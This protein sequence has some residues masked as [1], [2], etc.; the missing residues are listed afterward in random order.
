[1]K[2]F[3]TMEYRLYPDKEQVQSITDCLELEDGLFNRMADAAN[4]MKAAG[5]SEEAIAE[6]VSRVGAELRYGKTTV[7]AVKAQFRPQLSRLMSG[8]IERI[9]HRSR[10]RAERMADVWI[11]STTEDSAS[12]SGVGAVPVVWHRRIPEEAHIY[13]A[14][15]KESCYGARYYL[16]YYY[17]FEEKSVNPVPVQPDRI[18]GLDYAQDGLYVDSNGQSAGYPGFRLRERERLVRYRAN[19][20]RFKPGSRRWKT[21]R[22]RLAKL[23]THINNQRR[24]WQRKKVNELVRD[25]DMVCREQLDMKEMGEQTPMLLPK[26]RDNDWNSF[27][28]KLEAKM[29]QA[30][31]PVVTVDRFYPSSQICSVCGRRFGKIPLEQRTVQCPHCHTV[32]DRDYNAALNIRREGVRLYRSA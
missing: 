20:A 6:A 10:L 28:R 31:K 29:Q 16:V 23:E 14:A 21:H 25:C 19:A 7:A 27:C 12:I 24:D 11:H 5:K 22:C 9:C 13:R 32:L 17:Y 26:L 8:E 18:L 3:R 1:M 2:Q 15:V 30:G 4:D